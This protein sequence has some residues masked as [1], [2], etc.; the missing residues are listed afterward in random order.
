MCVWERGRKKCATCILPFVLIGEEKCR[1]VPKNVLA[2][3]SLFLISSSLPLLLFLPF[4]P[5]SSLS[6]H[7]LTSLLLLL[8]LLQGKR[9]A[10]LMLGNQHC[11]SLDEYRNNMAD[12]IM[13]SR[14]Q[15]KMGEVSV[16]CVLS[17]LHNVIRGLGYV[18]LVL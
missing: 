9:V 10:D 2:I 7:P 17:G 11:S 15:L 14:S 13:R 18:F 3:F 6:L 12:L 8:L 5:S 1:C 16:V 4:P